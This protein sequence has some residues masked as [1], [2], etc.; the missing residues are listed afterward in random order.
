MSELLGAALGYAAEGGAVLPLH[1]A[2]N[3]QCSCRRADCS[4]PAKH[5]R[6]R[7]GLHEATTDTDQIR[8]WWTR[9]PQANIGVR[10]G[11][12]SNLV[13]L[14]VDIRHGGHHTLADL[15]GRDPAVLDT[16]L[17]RTGGGG[18]HLYFRHPGHAVRNSA[19]LLGS[20]ID[21]RGDGGYIVAPPS[22]HAT[23][24]QYR[25]GD[26]RPIAPL[27]LSIDRAVEQSRFNITRAVNVRG[28]SAWTRAAFEREVALVAT[29]EPGA[30]NSTLIRAAFKLGQLVGAQALDR[31]SVTS[32]LITAATHAGLS[33]REAAATVIRG[34]NAG[35]ARPRS[36][37]TRRLR[38][39]T[40]ER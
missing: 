1:T 17:I 19:G 15:A 38:L 18:W 35:T 33:Q 8:Q 32:S 4:S 27:P 7:H 11:E 6:L 16:R 13:V 31:A 21:V 24:G 25:I 22:T 20:G 30:R 29:A 39:S 37:D 3:G 10:T 34:V 28:G 26:A 14:D 12:A 23:G 9:W 40:P 2:V 36:R 5:P